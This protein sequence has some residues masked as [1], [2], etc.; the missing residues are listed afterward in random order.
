MFLTRT[1]PTLLAFAFGAVAVLIYYIPH[2][3]AQEIERE[4]SLWLRILYAFAYFLGLYSILNL[5]WTRIQRRQ[6]GWAYSGVAIASFLV[7][8]LFVVYND[9]AGPFA[10]QASAGGYQWMFTYIHVACSSTMFSMLAF[11]IASAAYRTFRARSS[12]AAILLVAAIIL[13]VGRVP[14]GHAISDFFPE[15]VAWLM[16][17]P[18]LAAKR[19]IILGVS[20]GAIATSLRIIFGIERSYLGGGD[21]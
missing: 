12:D 6:G 9:G 17:V 14:I 13:M 8:F 11:Y 10:P 16:E 21:E 20:L 5:H 3:V 15:A 19:G 4:L 2:G 1:L 7:M 18:N